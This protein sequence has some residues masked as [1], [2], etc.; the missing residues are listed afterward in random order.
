MFIQHGAEAD[1]WWCCQTFGRLVQKNLSHLIC[2]ENLWWQFCISS[3]YGTASQSWRSVELLCP[4][5]QDFTKEK[6]T[7][8]TILRPIFRDHPGEPVPEENFWTLWCKGRL[9]EADTLT[10]RLGATPSGLT[11]AH[12]VLR[13]GCPS[14]R[15]ANSVKGLKA[16][17][18]EKSGCEIAIVWKQWTIPF[19]TLRQLVYHQLIWDIKCTWSRLARTYWQGSLKHVVAAICFV[20]WWQNE[21]AECFASL[22]TTRQ[23]LTCQEIPFTLFV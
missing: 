1:S 13:A 23:A 10:I 2:C 19:G 4:H 12:I 11:S 20:F 17:T 14:C 5:I 15:P 21:M 6:S 3:A 18:N 8:T 7:T 9:T 16:I 22:C